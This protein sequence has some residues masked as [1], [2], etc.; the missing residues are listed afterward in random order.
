MPCSHNKDFMCGG[1]WRNSVYQVSGP[2]G[3]AKIGTNI[4]GWMVL[5]PWI[6]PSLFYRFLGKTKEEGVAMDSY[7]V[8]DVLGASEGNKLMR[9]HWDSWY[10]E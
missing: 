3:K 4:G 2:P 10:T 1:N 9:A 5:E 8:C 7:T 6:T